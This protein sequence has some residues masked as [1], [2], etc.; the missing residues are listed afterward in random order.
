MSQENEKKGF[1]KN[2]KWTETVKPVI[3]YSVF[4]GTLALAIIIGV[5][6]CCL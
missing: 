6:V 5:L 2:I 4:G 3:G 1:L